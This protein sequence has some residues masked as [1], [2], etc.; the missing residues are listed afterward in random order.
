MKAAIRLISILLCLALL[1]ACAAEESDDESQAGMNGADSSSAREG[2]PMGDDK[3]TILWDK[4]ESAYPFNCDSQN[5]QAICSIV[6]EGLYRNNSELEAEPVL[7]ESCETE[8]GIVYKIRIKPGIALH[9]GGTLCAEDVVYSYELAQRSGNYAV[10]LECINSI[11][12]EGE[13]DLTIV[14]NKA[15]Y[16]FENLL[17]VPVIK[18]GSED[19]G[20]PS[21]TGPYYPELSQSRLTAFDSYHGGGQGNRPEYI[22][23]SDASQADVASDFTSGLLDYFCWDPDSATA[24]TIHNNFELKYYNSTCLHYLILNCYSS[25]VG[26][27]EFRRAIS[28]A[29]DKDYLTHNIYSAATPAKL[30]LSPALPYYDA[31]WEEDKGYSNSATSDIFVELGLIDSDDSGYLEF[32]HYGS[33]DLS[34]SFIVNS[35]SAEKEQA[36]EY[37]VGALRDVGIKAHLR[38]LDWKDY[39][40]ALV[41]G[42][43]D[44]AYA[45]VMLQP[46]FDF[47]RVLCGKLDYGNCGTDEAQSLINRLLA[48]REDDARAEAAKNLC[49]YVYQYG[50]VIPL[51]Y[52]K[53]AVIAQ[54]GVIEGLS[55]S[56][57]GVFSG[58]GNW[59]IDLDRDRT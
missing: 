13:L 49:D 20:M 45:E 54:Q 32:P 4:E 59:T 42:S 9:G 23:L 26:T 16:R 3:F 21:G 11:Y 22:Y 24:K 50:L 1:S 7:C 10:R 14:L 56:V 52:E 28:H 12:S 40:D 53:G 46:D 57:T 29:I 27:G 2:S 55:P 37:I 5:N 6:F 31:G 34:L 51:A 39:L 47:S 19:S 58:L 43:F 36:A 30:L 33:D 17:D 25:G 18:R 48:A 41:T 15:N 35:G 44:I 38:V 8:D